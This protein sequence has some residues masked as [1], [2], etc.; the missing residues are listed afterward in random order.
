MSVR[1]AKR[2][3]ID[4]EGEFGV[5][6]D[7]VP[8]G[9]SAAAALRSHQAD[10]ADQRLVAARDRTDRNED[11][12]RLGPGQ[13]GVLDGAVR[14]DARR[15]WR[16]RGAMAASHL[17]STVE[18]NGERFGQRQWARRWHLASTS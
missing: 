15:A 6:V 13:A 16:R 10:R 4:F 12:L 14:G 2:D 9:I 3:G 5:I 7:A 17:T 1:R 11:R 8:M 18:W